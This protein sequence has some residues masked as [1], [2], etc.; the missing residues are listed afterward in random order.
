[1]DNDTFDLIWN[2]LC[3]CMDA[4]EKLSDK[5]TVLQTELLEMHTGQQ[6]LF[7]PEPEW[8][9]EEEP[10]REKAQ[11][12]QEYRD[13]ISAARKALDR[14]EKEIEEELGPACSDNG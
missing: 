7:S 11:L 13:A 5:I 4:T 2:S 3:N 9:R 14:M 12:L 8:K 6:L 1:M 10:D